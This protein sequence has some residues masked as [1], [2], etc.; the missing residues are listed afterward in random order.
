MGVSVAFPKYDDQG[1]A[2]A[3]WRPVEVKF[4]LSP[5]EAAPVDVT[6]SSRGL[7]RG[8]RLQ[9]ANR[10]THKGTPTLDVT[11]PADGS[12]VSV[13]VGGAYPDAS[14]RFG[15]VSVE[16]RERTTGALLATHPTMVRVRKDANN[17]TTTERARFLRALAE[18]NGSAS[19]R[20]LDF[21]EMHVGGLPD[22]EA[23]GGPGFLPWHRIYLLD[24]ERALQRRNAEVALPYWRFDL[25]APRVF[26]RSFMGVPGPED[27]ALFSAA[28]PLTAWVAGRLPG[29]ERGPGVGP[30]R[31][32][33]F[34]PRR[35]HWISEAR[36]TRASVPFGDAGEPAWPCTQRASPRT[37]HQSRDGPAGSALLPVALQCRPAIDSVGSSKSVCT[38]RMSSVPSRPV[39]PARD[40]SW[41]ASC[42]RGADRCHRRG[43]RPRRGVA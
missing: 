1:R 41:A 38:I 39:R 12:S 14:T 13:W 11:V 32:P 5:S 16:V 3:T 29:V 43:R 21:R 18:L 10:L 30:Q 19:G 8:G 15:D 34:V 9:F 4:A 27:R 35:R 31:C 6:V 24:C 36:R 2:F 33:C 42:G 23:H 26:T 37:D 20:F 17:L 40:T 25:A 28:N 22:I 7:D